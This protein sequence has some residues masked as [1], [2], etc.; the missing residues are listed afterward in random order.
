MKFEAVGLLTYRAP[1]ACMAEIR[2]AGLFVT[3]NVGAWTM[4][5]CSR[6]LV[7]KRCTARQMYE[8]QGVGKGVSDTYNNTRV[9]MVKD[10]ECLRESSV[11]AA[12]VMLTQPLRLQVR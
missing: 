4:G 7:K 12:K 3:L 8:Q 9:P 1:Q 10:V 5:I 6:N 2:M 11:A